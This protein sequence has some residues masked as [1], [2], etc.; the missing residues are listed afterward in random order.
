MRFSVTPS[1][2]KRS[3][4]GRDFLLAEVELTLAGVELFFARAELGEALPQFGPFDFERT[5]PFAEFLRLAVE[6][7]DLGFEARLPLGDLL[8]AAIEFGGTFLRAGAVGGDFFDSL[9]ELALPMIELAMPRLDGGFAVFELF[10]AIGPGLAIFVEGGEA[11][12]KLGVVVGKLGLAFAESRF[13][14]V[15]GLSADVGQFGGAGVDDDF[16]L[17]E[18]VL[19][20]FEFRSASFKLVPGV[21]RATV[22]RF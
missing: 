10:A 12:V 13:T 20:E 3:E 18:V 2:S 11:S 7:G 19:L 9:I 5:G 15:E 1:R 4:R 17:G 8:L 21:L 16:A 14:F 22:G 6:L